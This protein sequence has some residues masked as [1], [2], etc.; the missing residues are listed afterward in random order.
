MAPPT[1]PALLGGEAQDNAVDSILA[2]PAR[3]DALGNPGEATEITRPRGTAQGRGGPSQATEGKEQAIRGSAGPP[4]TK[5]SSWRAGPIRPTATQPRLGE[6]HQNAFDNQRRSDPVARLLS[7]G[8]DPGG[9]DQG[10]RR[11]RHHLPGRLAGAGL[12]VGSGD[13]LGLGRAPLPQPDAEQGYRADDR[14]PLPDLVPPVPERVLHDGD[15]PGCAW[16]LT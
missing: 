7:R 16:R 4:M 1:R 11:P 14:E 3:A 12:V 8:L 10:G 9:P 6:K 15:S 2:S 13:R 5:S